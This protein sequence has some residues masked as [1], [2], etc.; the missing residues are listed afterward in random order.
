MG[1]VINVCMLKKST[2]RRDPKGRIVLEYGQRWSEKGHPELIWVIVLIEHTQVDEQAQTMIYLEDLEGTECT[3][4][5][6]E[7]YF[8]K[9]FVEVESQKNEQKKKRNRRLINSDNVRNMDYWETSLVIH[10]ARK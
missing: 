8:R 10:G 5:F 9:W 2:P 1:S 4:S 6:S 7:K 3:S